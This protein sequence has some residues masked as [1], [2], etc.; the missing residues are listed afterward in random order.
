MAHNQPP[1]K[2]GKTLLS[3]FKKCDEQNDA[4]SIQDAP[5]VSNI[6]TSIPDLEPHHESHIPEQRDFESNFIERDPGL[7]MQ[8]GKHPV[9]QRDE[10]RR[11]YIKAGA[12]QPILSEY[13]RTKIGNQY[14]RFQ[15]I[16]FKQFPWLEYS[17]SK[18]KAY[19][20]PCFIFENKSDTGG[21][22][23]TSY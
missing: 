6:D 9:N 3:F 13:P 4:H 7:R 1:A 17:P 11:A 8:I 22:F 15:P 18:D 5:S 16:W 12:Y 23:C 19:Y 10:I 20:F 21:P 2:R 14:R